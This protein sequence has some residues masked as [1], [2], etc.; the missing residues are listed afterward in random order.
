MTRFTVE[1]LPQAE[2]EFRETFLWYF[3]RSPVFADALR[4][5]VLLKMDALLID[6]D[7]WPVDED[8]VRFRILSKRF[9]YTIHYDLMGTSVTIL[10]IAPQR[11]Q[12]RYWSDRISRSGSV[13]DD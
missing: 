13:F 2:A 11:R 1:I 8:G 5:E 6:A 10:A 9:K 3:E 12:P 7:T 4:S